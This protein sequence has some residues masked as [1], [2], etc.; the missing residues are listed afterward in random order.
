MPKIE[1]KRVKKI[2][3]MFI[4]SLSEGATF[5]K[6][7]EGVGINRTTIW[8]WRREDEIFDNE[9]N[10]VLDS[11]IQD[12][13]DALFK[14]ATENNNVTAQIFWLKSRGGGRWRDKPEIKSP[15]ETDLSEL[16]DEELDELLDLAG[17]AAETLKPDS[18]NYKENKGKAT[19]EMKE[20]STIW[21][22]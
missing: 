6:A 19:Y 8:N 5:T 21:D 7:C 3:E 12:V 2:K 4:E 11:R 20:G 17:R 13:E 18:K 9:I 15:G 10:F 14:N 16:T 22:K 1:E